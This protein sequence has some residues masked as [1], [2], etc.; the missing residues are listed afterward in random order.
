M[1]RGEEDEEGEGRGCWRDAGLT[2]L[3]GVRFA[4][5]YILIAC[6]IDQDL[7]FY[8]KWRFIEICNFTRS[9]IYA[10]TTIY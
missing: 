9:M 4:N 10:K 3:P 2:V 5:I 7:L 6:M 8:E 1:W